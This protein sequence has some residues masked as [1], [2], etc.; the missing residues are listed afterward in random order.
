MSLCAPFHGL[1]TGVV[2]SGGRSGW[3]LP[4]ALLVCEMSVWNLGGTAE[5]SRE[6]GA[7][8]CRIIRRIV[9]GSVFGKLS[10]TIGV[11]KCTYTPPPL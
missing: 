10:Q 1:R 2:L 4:A 9:M 11:L 6:T 3:L 5:K 7:L 8:A